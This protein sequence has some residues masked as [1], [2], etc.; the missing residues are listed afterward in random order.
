MILSK[1]TLSTST[2][3][4]VRII[5]SLLLSEP[6]MLPIIADVP[7]NQDCDG[8]YQVI[9]SR[10]IRVLSCDRVIGSRIVIIG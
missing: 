8:G 1:N 10:I 9:D 6:K 4:V 2:G 7:T 5:P 3:P